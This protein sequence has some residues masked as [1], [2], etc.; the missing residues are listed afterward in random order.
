[1]TTAERNLK[2]YLT[3]HGLELPPPPEPFGV[4]RPTIDVSPLNNHTSF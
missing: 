2:N 3:K 1:M 4:Y